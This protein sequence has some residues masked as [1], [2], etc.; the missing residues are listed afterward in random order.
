MVAGLE[1]ILETNEAERLASC[2]GFTEGPLWHPDGFFYFVDLRVEPT[3][4]RVGI[5]GE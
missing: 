2:F 3:L 5:R 1:S 4:L